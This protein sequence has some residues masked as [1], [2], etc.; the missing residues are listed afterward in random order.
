MRCSRATFAGDNGGSELGIL[1]DIDAETRSSRVQCTVCAW[2]GKQSP[3][4][5]ETWTMAMADR[6]R[7]TTAIWRAMRKH[8]YQAK[9]DGPL[10]THR[11][12]HL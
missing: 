12:G 9:T 1:E 11:K 7:T 6:T 2:I 10:S 5:R 8:G 3:G 4:D